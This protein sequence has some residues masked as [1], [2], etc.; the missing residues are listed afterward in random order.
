MNGYEREMNLLDEQLERGEISDKEYRDAVKELN[1]QIRDEA[2]MA[3][4]D[5]YNDVMGRY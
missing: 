1:W 2:T 5:A 3:A 4:E